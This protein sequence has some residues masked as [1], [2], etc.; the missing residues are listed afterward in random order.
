MKIHA[1]QTGRVQVKCAQLIGQ[2]HGLKRRL[3]PLTDTVWSDW[4]PTYAFA[5]EHADGVIL[6]DTGSNAGLT[7]LPRWHPY[8]RLAVRFD[9]DREQEVG[10]QLGRIGIA[11]RDVKKV[12]L[13]HMHIDHDSGLKDLPHS[14]VFA[15]PGEVKCASGFAG[16]IRGYLPQRWPADF[17]PKPLLFDDEAFG[18]F[19]RSRRL[20]RDGSVIAIPTPGHT[21]HHISIA[22]VDEA[23][24]VLIAGDA[25]YTEANLQAGVI[26]GVAEAEAQAALTLKQLSALAAE[27]PIVFLP[28]HDPDSPERLTMQRTVSTSL[29]T[30]G[31]QAHG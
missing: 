1:L 20:T 22:V 29:T 9:I 14:E 3:G 16:Q 4:L 6:I 11:P 30:A 24:T 25:S 19:A 23:A 13:T 5:V 12:V 28:T 21:A 15:S 18:P 31:A 17:D 2:G 8:F 10:V 27:R 26:D 7:N